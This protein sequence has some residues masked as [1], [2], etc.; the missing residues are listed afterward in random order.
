[1]IGESLPAYQRVDGLCGVCLNSYDFVAAV[2]H[3]FSEIMVGRISLLDTSTS[4][5]P[6]DLYRY[7]GA[8]ARQFTQRASASHDRRYS[9]DA[10]RLLER[11][12]NRRFQRGRKSDILWRNIDG[13]TVDWTTSGSQITANQQITMQGNIAT[14]DASWSVG[15]RRISSLIVTARR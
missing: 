4:Y 13:A 7:A 9:C 3:E 14:P 15:R 10:G 12:W 6:M 2:E 11:G 1:V 8:N 5:T